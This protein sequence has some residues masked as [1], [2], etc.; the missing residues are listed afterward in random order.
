[1]PQEQNAPSYS[2]QEQIRREK[3]AALQEAGQDPY[4]LT[5]VDVT[6]SSARISENYDEMEGKEVT[7]AG[8]IM[9]RNVMGK[10]SFA[11]L[12]DKD[13]TMQFY[14]RR[15]DV[16]EEVYAGFKKMDIGDLLS[17]KGT[18][19]KTRTGEIS[20]HASE[21]I[22]LAKCLHPLPEKF[23]GLTDTDLRFRQRYLI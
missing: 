9:A 21:I 4:V 14:V 18:V 10:A 7:I 2:E 5:K 15:D 16:G 20:V 17:V 19:F 6:A 11:R 3:L 12:Q 23:H 22:L 13:G 1:M 8:R